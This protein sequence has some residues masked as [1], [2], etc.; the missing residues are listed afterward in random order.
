MLPHGPVKPKHL[1]ILPLKSFTVAP[2][3]I[4]G[5]LIYVMD[6]PVG[7][8]EGMI[9]ISADSPDYLA[10]VQAELARL[11]ANDPLCDPSLMARYQTIQA[12]L[13]G[14]DLNQKI[15]FLMRDRQL[16]VSADEI[17]NEKLGTRYKNVGMGGLLFEGYKRHCQVND[18][19]HFAV[20][21]E[22]LTRGMNN[23]NKVFMV[24]Q[25]G[26][27]SW[28]GGTGPGTSR[29]AKTTTGKKLTQSWGKAA[30]A[31]LGGWHAY[32]LVKNSATSVNLEAITESLSTKLAA[33]RGF[34]SQEIDT[35]DGTYENGAPK[36]ATIVTWSPGCRDL[37]GKL[38]GG[39]DDYTSVIVAQDKNKQPIKVDND[40]NMIRAGDKNQHGEIDS[41]EKVLADGSVVPATEDEYQQAMAISEDRISGLGESL[42]SFISMG[43]RDGIGKQ[44]QNK[45]IRPL[46]PPQ[47]NQLFEFYGIDFGKAYKG[48]NPILNS[49]QD[50][51]SFDNPTD[52][53][54]RF[55]NISILYD[56]PLSEKMKGLYLL[57]AQRNL[58]TPE[59][60]AAIVSEYRDKGDVAFADKFEHYP[61]DGPF[62]DLRLLQAEEQKYRD[63]AAETLEAASAAPTRKERNQLIKKAEQYTTYAEKIKQIH[64]LVIKTDVEVLKKF[65]KRINLTPSQIDI[66]DN[67]EKLTARNA[68]TTSPDGT[69]RLN[70]IQ[71]KREDRVAWQLAETGENRFTLVCEERNGNQ[72][73]KLGNIRDKLTHFFAQ[74]EEFASISPKISLANGRLT[75]RNLTK[76]EIAILSTHL[77][78]DKVALER[79]LPYRSQAMRDEFHQRLAPKAPQ[80]QMVPP[81]PRAASAPLMQR[82]LS[83]LDLFDDKPKHVGGMFQLKSKP[84]D[85][86]EPLLQQDNCELA[87]LQEF[88][89]NPENQIKY[90]ITQVEPVTLGKFNSRPGLAIRF[91]NPEGDPITVIA[92]KGTSLNGIQ[93]AIPQGMEGPAFG[94]IAEK[95]CQ[96][97]VDVAKPDTQFTLLR[98]DPHQNH[99]LEELIQGSIQEGIRQARFSEEGKP[100]LAKLNG[101]ERSQRHSM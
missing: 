97:A 52:L 42:L 41:W 32:Y 76:D 60:K 2:G 83:E 31:V 95:I 94:A 21:I 43:D 63:L 93:Y 78:E 22:K 44:G 20:H 64:E 101:A 84:K 17:R 11:E 72:P 55:V 96:M 29:I 46:D 14:L 90:H 4:V 12:Q 27:M 81:R 100:S 50:D 57:A 30:P 68:T 33:L 24:K 53:K 98:K 67:M 5:G 92:E 80:V 88:L 89:S 65:E 77:T 91:D 74:H 15:A 59:Q 49:L 61:E 75:I 6:K 8:E 23:P 19:D 7:I 38:A 69:V 28:N 9:G 1:D 79:Q 54:K 51:F 48:P 73:N 58:L 45:A 25:D 16:E 56:N 47:G 34:K 40:G 36:I 37:S 66:L 85:L 3:D 10:F 13:V 26:E 82:Q 71:V 99:Y 86:T 62:S 39:E 70:H 18:T 87:V 35:I